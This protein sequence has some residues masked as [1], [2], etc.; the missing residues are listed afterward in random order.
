MLIKAGLKLLRHWG[1]CVVNQTTDFDLLKCIIARDKLTS[2]YNQH[3][4]LGIIIS[5]LYYNAN[6][7]SVDD[8]Q[9]YAFVVMLFQQKNLTPISPGLPNYSFF[10][11]LLFHHRM[12]HDLKKLVLVFKNQSNE[13]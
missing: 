5:G 2:H 10:S 13:N 1:Y 6:S 11:C 8:Q 12:T 7:L 3:F 4:Y 9:D